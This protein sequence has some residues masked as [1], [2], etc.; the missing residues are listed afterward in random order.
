MN[1]LRSLPLSLPATFFESARSGPP[2]NTLRSLPLSLPAA[3]WDLVTFF[4][5]ARAYAKLVGGGALSLMGVVAIIWGGI[6]SVKKLMANQQDQTSWL[7][8]AGLIMVGGALM[9]GGFSLIAGIAEGGKTTIEDLG[10]G[11]IVFSMFFGG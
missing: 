7:K 5:S 3:Q 2:M 10:G 8:I 11:F 4:E 1:T 9:V 6:L